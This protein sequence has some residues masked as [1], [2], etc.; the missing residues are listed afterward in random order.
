MIDYSPANFEA[1]E[2]KISRSSICEGGAFLHFIRLILQ[3][4]RIFF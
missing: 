4:V 1:G 2:P 3:L